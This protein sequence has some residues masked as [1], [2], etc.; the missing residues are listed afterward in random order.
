MPSGPWRHTR[1][2]VCSATA[3]KMS[4]AA[5]SACVVASMSA[6]VSIRSARPWSSTSSTATERP[7]SKSGVSDTR[8]GRAVGASGTST[9][10]VRWPA[11]PLV[12]ASTSGD[13]IAAMSSRCQ[14]GAAHNG[15]PRTASRSTPSSSRWSFASSTVPSRSTRRAG[16]AS[17]AMSTRTWV[18]RRWSSVS[19]SV[20]RARRS[21][22]S[23]RDSSPVTV[24][25]SRSWVTVLAPASRGTPAR[26]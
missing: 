5:A 6:S 21:S 4:S 10:T 22:T 14:I 3:R 7:S 2:E 18:A 23:A 24:A 16:P 9:S 1:S 19:G 11:R 20:S 13:K 12:P 25:P 26:G 8:I 17:R 15:R